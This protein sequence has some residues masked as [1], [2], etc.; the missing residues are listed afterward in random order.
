M[1][2]LGTKEDLAPKIK[3]ASGEPV[4]YVPVLLRHFSM[5]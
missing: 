4:D 3:N 1:R 2:E 5:S